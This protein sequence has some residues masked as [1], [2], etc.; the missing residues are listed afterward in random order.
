MK[1]ERLIILTTHHLDEVEALA[2]Q[3]KVIGNDPFY[4]EI[5]KISIGHSKYIIINRD[6]EPHPFMENP[7]MMDV[8]LII[9]YIM[10]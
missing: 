8:V 2:D 1:R 9:L 6:D 5:L 7:V 3:I 4:R 10:R